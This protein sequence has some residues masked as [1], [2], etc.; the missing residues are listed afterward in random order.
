MRQRMKVEVYDG[1]GY[2]M[3]SIHDKC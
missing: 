3:E 1:Y 2:G